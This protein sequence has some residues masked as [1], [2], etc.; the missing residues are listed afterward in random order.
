MSASY[1]AIAFVLGA[2][3]MAVVDRQTGSGTVPDAN[4]SA[5]VAN[6][7]KCEMQETLSWRSG[8]SRV[9]PPATW[10]IRL[11]RDKWVLV[12][13]NGKPITGGQKLPLGV[14]AQ[15][16]TLIEKGPTGTGLMVDR[17]TGQVSGSSFPDDKSFETTGHCEPIAIQPNM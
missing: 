14:D 6:G 12:S 10:L 5:S 4:A 2:G 17:T 9:D 7:L 13:L 15:S 16:Y 8:G 1:L 11:E 3:V